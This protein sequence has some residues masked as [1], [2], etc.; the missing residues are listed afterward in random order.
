MVDIDEITY[1][2]KSTL[3]SYIIFERVKWSRDKK[4]FRTAATE[5]LSRSHIRACAKKEQK[6]PESHIRMFIASIL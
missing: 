6:N 1:I 3:G 4:S 5:S 2:N